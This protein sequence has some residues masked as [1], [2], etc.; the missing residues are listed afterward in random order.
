[1][2]YRR[3]FYISLSLALSLLF[4]IAPTT[5]Y[6]RGLWTLKAKGVRNESEF[7]LLTVI[8][9]HFRVGEGT[10]GRTRLIST[11]GRRALNPSRAILT[12]S[13]HQALVLVGVDSSW[14]MPMYRVVSYWVHRATHRRTPLQ[15]FGYQWELDRKRINRS[16]WRKPISKDL[17]GEP[18]AWPRFNV[19]FRIYHNFVM[20]IFILEDIK[21]DSAYMSRRSLRK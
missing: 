11:E 14:C 19:R 4:L 5:N 20:S 2:I 6:S 15:R 12:S 7:R 17:R 10:R 3:W 21:E 9:V 16:S 18:S 1:M 13:T 8:M